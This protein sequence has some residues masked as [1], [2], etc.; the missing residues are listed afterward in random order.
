MLGRDHVRLAGRIASFLELSSSERKS[1]YAG[2]VAP[3]RERGRGESHHTRKKFKIWDELVETRFCLNKGLKEKAASHLGTSLHF[4][5][6]SCIKSGTAHDAIEEML[7]E[8]VFIFPEI[9]VL[10]LKNLYGK[11]MEIRPAEDLDLIMQNVSYGGFLTAFHAYRRTAPAPEDLLDRRA[12]G[13]IFVLKMIISLCLFSLF[14][15]LDTAP[16]FFMTAPCFT[17]LF[18]FSKHPDYWEYRKWFRYGKG[19]EN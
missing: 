16:A 14:F 5:A 4:L 9:P 19:T 13:K 12:A 15:F 17:A 7:A 3:D 6:D 1:L 10:S 2:T 8:K 18:I 11:I